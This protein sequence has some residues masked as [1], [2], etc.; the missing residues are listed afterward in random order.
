M[1]GGAVGRVIAS[2][3]PA[4]PEGALVLA[5]AAWRDVAVLDAAHV[6]GAARAAGDPAQLPPRRAR[7]ARADRL[8]RAVPGG[9]LPAR[10]TPSSSR[11][12]PGA[13]GSLVGQFA[14]LRGASAVVGSAGTPE[15]VALADRGARLHRR[16][17]LPR[18]PGRRAARGRGARR[19]RRLLR[20]RRRRA[21]GG[22]HRRAA[23]STAGRR[24]AARSPAY[25]A[26]SRRPGRATC[27]CCVAKQLSLR[28]FIV[29][30][31]AD[32][33]PEFMEAVTR[34]A[35]LGRARRPG[36][37]ARGAGGRRA[38]LPRPPARRQ[39]RQDDR[40]LADRV[41]GSPGFIAAGAGR[42]L[43]C[44]SSSPAGCACG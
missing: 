18:R 21:P 20:Q 3:S 8:G 19:H 29:G 28:G 33:R 2:R 6:P 5:D 37:R 43:A 26:V 14:R 41:T 27:R 30:D 13:V 7:H 9:R 16:V 40:A 25:N 31:H 23:A 12:P 22:R 34:L 15:K 24:S 35:A 44:G 38:G 42:C 17:R 39:H 4:V 32:L 11:A 10:A 1:K 36:D